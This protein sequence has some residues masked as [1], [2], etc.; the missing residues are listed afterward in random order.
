[1]RGSREVYGHK[2][3][4]KEARFTTYKGHFEELKVISI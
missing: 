1:M 4:N 2:W 3:V